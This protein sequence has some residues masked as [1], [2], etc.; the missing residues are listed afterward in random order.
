MGPHP[1]PSGHQSGQA[2]DV[3]DPVPNE[4]TRLLVGPEQ[5]GERLDIFVAGATQLSRRAAR[6]LI[7]DGLV[8][9]NG[10]PLR[11]Q[12]RP[13]TIGD[14]VDVLRPSEELGVPP[15]PEVVTPELLF[16][17]QFLLVAAKPAG[18]LSQPAE[19]RSPDDPSFDHQVL[20]AL[21]LSTGRRPFLRMLHR[22]DRMT[23]G[24]VL[25]ARTSSALQPLTQAWAEGRVERSYLAVVEGHPKM[26]SF[27]IDRPIARDR[28]HRWRFRCHESG[29]AARTI[30]Q[31]VAR[32]DSGLSV[33]R[34]LLITGRTHQVRVH[35]SDV[36]YPVLGDWLY[37]SKR[38][39]EADRPLLHA[40]SLTFPHPDT[41]EELRVECPTPQDLA[42]FIP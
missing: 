1:R 38:A 6:R 34:C 17:D 9:R 23:S 2:P 40:A 27:E 42:K 26:D 39:D 29:R 36:G 3:S 18:V 22:L 20:L 25:F 41:G 32:L 19:N 7:T 11:V 5:Q 14:V 12:S 35:L 37:G 33:V 28:G 21:A 24:A 15:L 30:V 31:V 8:W 13:L 16:H 10:D 4:L